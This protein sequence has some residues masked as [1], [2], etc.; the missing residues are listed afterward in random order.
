MVTLRDISINIQGFSPYINLLPVEV[1][2]MAE[3]PEEIIFNYG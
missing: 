3:K 2:Y 1:A